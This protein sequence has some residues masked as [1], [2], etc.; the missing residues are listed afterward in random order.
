MLD[1][2]QVQFYLQIH[3]KSVHFSL[4]WNTFRR[5]LSLTGLPIS[6]FVFLQSILHTTSQSDQAS[7]LEPLIVFHCTKDN[8]KIS[9]HN[10]GACVA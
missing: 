10:S 1:S 2:L 4:T 9:H 6:T 3:L 7:N 5:A 8:I